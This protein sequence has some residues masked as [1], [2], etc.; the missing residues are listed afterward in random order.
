[1]WTTQYCYIM[2]VSDLLEQPCNKS[3]NINKVVPNLLTTWDKQCEQNLLTTCWQTSKMWDYC[4]CSC[5]SWSDQVV[6]DLWRLL[7]SRYQ[8]VFAL[9][10][11]ICCD[12][13]G[14]S[15]YHLV[16]RSPTIT[17]LLQVV[18]TRLIQ[19]VRNKFLR[20]WCHQLVMWIRYQTCWNNL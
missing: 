19:A 7:S 13:S 1:M 9:L 4:A 20:A 18:P 11:P 6:T 14:T 15:C 3:D 10:V 8:N 12:K 5:A 17:D 16:T 2:T